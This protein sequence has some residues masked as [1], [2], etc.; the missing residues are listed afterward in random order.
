VKQNPNMTQKKKNIPTVFEA[1][2]FYTA[3]Q[4][5]ADYNAKQNE[6][7]E[8]INEKKILNIIDNIKKKIQFI[9]ISDNNHTYPEYKSGSLTSGEIRFIRS[10]GYNVEYVDGGL[11]GDYWKISW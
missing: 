10:L 3:K 4:A 6:K 5:R 7:N 2:Q 8:F 1:S 11:G 9:E